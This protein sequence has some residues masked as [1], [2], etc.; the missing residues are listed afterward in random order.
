MVSDLN[1]AIA[2]G[3]LIGLLQLLQYFAIKH[4]VIIRT[5]KLLCPCFIRFIIYTQVNV[6]MMFYYNVR[7]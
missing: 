7:Q 6:K 1:K 4:L 3:Y 2:Y 5:R